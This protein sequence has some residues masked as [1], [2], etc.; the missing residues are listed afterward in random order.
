[1][2]FLRVAKVDGDGGCPFHALADFDLYDGQALRI[3]VVDY[4]SMSR[5]S[6]SQA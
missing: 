1:M 2:K 5:L 3:D 6:P 4:T